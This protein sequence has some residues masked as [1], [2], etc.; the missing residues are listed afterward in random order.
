MFKEIL[1]DAEIRM[2]KSVS[3]AEDHLS[4][5]RTGRAQPSLVEDLE[6]DY[7]GVATPL[8]QLA[9]IIAEDA[10]TLAIQAYDSSITASIDKA[11]RVCE[12][13]LNPVLQGNLLRVPLPPLTQERRK[14]Y[15]KLAKSEAENGKVA[16]RNVRRDVNAEIKAYLK[17]KDISADDAKKLEVQ[18]QELTNQMVAK[19]DVA[20][21]TKEQ[22]L[23]SV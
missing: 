14:E 8:K 10:R 9:N 2:Q 23:L 1:S 16:I 20:L 18:V 6:V 17:D 7:Y 19:M 3:V 15:V 11:L 12:L 22:E 21:A 4:K 13:G 5:I